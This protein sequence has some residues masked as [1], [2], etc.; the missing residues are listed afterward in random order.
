MSDQVEFTMQVSVKAAPEELQGVLDK[1]GEMVKLKGVK[2]LPIPGGHGGT[3]GI[4]PGVDIGR[5]LSLT[6][7]QRPGTKITIG[8]R[9]PGIPV[10]HEHLGDREIVLLNKAEFSKAMEVRLSAAAK[11]LPGEMDV[12]GSMEMLAKLGKMVAKK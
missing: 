8:P 12:P 4:W 11:A 10:P 5:P 9:F 2:L 7:G 3:Q 1:L 6:L